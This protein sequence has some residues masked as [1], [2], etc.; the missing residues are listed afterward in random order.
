[1]KNR[2]DEPI[3]KS[4][5]FNHKGTEED[6]Q[7]FLKSLVYDYYDFGETKALSPREKKDQEESEIEL[8]IANE[9]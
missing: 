1:M 6:W 8:D 9:M 5:M 3:I 2:N 7:L 4:V